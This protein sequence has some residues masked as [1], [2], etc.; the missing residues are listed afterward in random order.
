MELYNEAFC[1]HFVICC[2]IR[3]Q[4]AANALVLMFFFTLFLLGEA[5]YPQT[6][7]SL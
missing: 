2:H 4:I 6:F 7:V 5:E 1:F 3:W